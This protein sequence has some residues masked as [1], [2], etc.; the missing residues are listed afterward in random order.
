MILCCPALASSGFLPDGWQRSSSKTA[1]ITTQHQLHEL[2]R[3]CHVMTGVE[4]ALDSLFIEVI[5]HAN[6]ATPVS[7]LDGIAIVSESS[8]LGYF[9]TPEVTNRTGE[10]YVPWV[11]PAVSKKDCMVVIASVNAVLHAPCVALD[12]RKALDQPFQECL[13][14]CFC[15]F[16]TD[17]HGLL[18]ANVFSRPVFKINPH[19]QQA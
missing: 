17:K 15:V 5:D 8:P 19:D 12:G 11:V 10:V 18:V 14:I 4:Q 6:A 13:P 1:V 2:I 7:G 16:I 9:I 3:F